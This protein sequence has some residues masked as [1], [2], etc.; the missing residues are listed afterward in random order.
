MPTSDADDEVP[1]SPVIDP[2]PDPDPSRQPP[3]PGAPQLGM[4]Q[5][6]FGHDVARHAYLDVWSPEPL[7]EENS[8]IGAIPD[9]ASPP[10]FAAARP[11]LPEPWWDG[12][13]DVTQAWWR[14][15][16]LAF[17]H[18]RAVH[19]GTGFIAPFIDTAFNDHLFLW[20]SVFILAF[21]RYG[22]RSFDFQRTLDNL[23]AAQHPDGFISRERDEATGAD[24]FHR[25][26]PSSTGP[27]V[28]AWSEIEHWRA[29]GDGDRLA[30]VWPAVAAYHRWTA[31][32]RSWPSG[33][34]W[35]TGFGSGMDNQRR[36]PGHDAITHHGWITWIDATCQQLLSARCL[37]EAAAVIGRDDQ[38]VAELRTEADG[39]ERFVRE[40]M[41][42]DVAGTY[43]D[44]DRDQRPLSRGTVAAYWALLAGVA[45]GERLERFL[46]PL[47][48][49]A[50][51]ARHHRVPSLA[52]DE[53]DYRPDG[54]YWRGAVW[55]P[56]TYMV[57]RGL[58]A[59]G[60]T[61]LAAVIAANHHERVLEV[62]ATTGTYW[63]SYAPDASAPGRPAKGDFV[64]WTGLTPIAVLLEQRFGLHPVAPDHLV[65]D[66]RLLDAHGVRRYP[67]GGAAVDLECA[68]RPD[69]VAA[70]SILVRGA[71]AARITVRWDG[72]A[73][74]IPPGTAVRG[75]PPDPDLTRCTP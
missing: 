37:L 51:F 15:W 36:A 50:R 60:A 40:H 41:W 55:S 57:L 74:D 75:T 53:P 14:A 6:Q 12:R 10:S 4:R 72:G 16:E 42:D 3:H 25:H 62:L 23:Y 64:G 8:F 68:G 61:D 43:A 21:A 2:D 35:S 58:D 39:L 52:A 59:V 31:R 1:S 54:G 34:M 49:P 7:V 17:S 9:L 22:R 19:P 32:H 11:Q 28:L 24:L 69:A 66:V 20:D 67:L 70:P 29:T 47:A 18:L 46:A 38:P 30:A 73:V 5:R 13:P 33:G 44:L 27:N 65:W 56:T 63:E 48:D 26:D 71:P 45:D